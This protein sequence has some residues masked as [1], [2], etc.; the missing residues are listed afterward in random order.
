MPTSDIAQPPAVSEAQLS[1]AAQLAAEVGDDAIPSGTRWRLWRGELLRVVLFGLAGAAIGWLLGYPVSGVCLALVLSLLLHVRHL[2]HLRLWLFRPKSYQLPEPNGLWGTVFDGLI[3]LQRKNRKKKK[4]LAAMLAEFQASTAALP[5]GAVV[6]GSRGEI[7]WF[8]SAARQLLGLRQAQDIGIRVPNLVRSPAF[9]EYFERG[10]FDGEVEVQS[11]VNGSKTLSLRAIRYGRGQL[12]LIVR[13]V[14]ERMMLDAARR[15]FV[16][17]ASH[18]LRT[19]L[20]VLRGYLDL[21]E[22]DAQTAKGVTGPLAPWQSPL[23]EMRNQTLRMEALVNDMLKLARLESSR[24]QMRDEPLD[25]PGL[26]Q[27]VIEDARQLSKGQHRIDV[28]ADAA[29]SLLGGEIEL[30]SIFANLITNAVRYTPPG[31]TIRVSWG[32]TIEGACFTVA[33]TGIGIAHKDIPRLTERF[34]RV[35][36]G[37]SRASGGTGLGLSIVKH[38][39]ESFDARMEIE[40]EIGVGTTFRCTFPPHRVTDVT[41]AT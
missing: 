3:D 23:M 41:A 9:T 40:S 2:I 4:K 31:G 5:D 10:A 12:L 6:L 25:V 20:T 30:H 35:D 14:S 22:M 21:M 33:D 32:R 28:S 38:A 39:I 1:R 11:P 8:N 16:A 17:N 24:A 19:P 13:D 27:R 37:R 29:L 26:I 18:E 36:V 15:D 7:A 34:Y